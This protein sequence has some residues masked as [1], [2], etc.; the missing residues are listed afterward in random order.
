MKEEPT[1]N[2]VPISTHIASQIY[3]KSN[4]EG[5]KAVLR[6]LRKAVRAPAAI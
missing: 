1:S 4:K 5:K 6:T 2:Y 3:S